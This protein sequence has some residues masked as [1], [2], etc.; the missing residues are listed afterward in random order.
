MASDV[1]LEILC[2]E[3]KHSNKRLQVIWH[4]NGKKMQQTCSIRMYI[5]P[6]TNKAL[7]FHTLFKKTHVEQAKGRFKIECNI[8]PPLL[9]NN[10]NNNKEHRHQHNNNQEQKQSIKVNKKKRRQQTMLDFCSMENGTKK[11]RKFNDHHTTVVKQ[12]KY[13]NYFIRD[14]VRFPAQQLTEALNRFSEKLGTAT[15]FGLIPNI[16]CFSSDKNFQRICKQH[17][18]KEQDYFS[19]QYDNIDFWKNKIAWCFPPYHRKTI[20]DCINS[21]KT[22]KMKG[23]VCIPYDRKMEFIGQA[24]RICKEYIGMK[25]TSRKDKIY[26]VDGSNLIQRCSFET[27][28]FYFD[29]QEIDK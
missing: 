18:T 5:E 26:I 19:F 7:G 15:L 13:K 23:Y 3:Y 22:R 8:L 17:I 6:D 28:I 20:V 2:N 11:K 1:Q 16:D 14:D 29:Y 4:C 9:N 24:Q 12:R 21:F 10:N 27:M 25:A